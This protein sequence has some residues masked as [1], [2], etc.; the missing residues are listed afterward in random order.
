[1]KF[2]WK[3]LVVTFVIGIAI[4][5]FAAGSI[6]GLLHK[7]IPFPFPGQNA[8]SPASSNNVLVSYVGISGTIDVSSANLPSQGKLSGTLSYSASSN[9]FAAALGSTQNYTF[10][11][12]NYS[13]FTMR[14]NAM[15]TQTQ[16]F[17][18]LVVHP[19]L[20]SLVSPNSS[21]NFTLSIE[22][23]S[24]N[25]SGQLSISFSANLTKS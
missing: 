18:T 7:I 14:I 13:P 25:Y 17:S 19:A 11:I 24:H 23:P 22:V 15:S 21:G 10:T 1:M 20:P 9:G 8:S 16:N 12:P 2:G 5:M 4:G 3:S 6:T